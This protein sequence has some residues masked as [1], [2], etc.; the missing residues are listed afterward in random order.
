MGSFGRYDG[1]TETIDDYVNLH[2][3]PFA[4]VAIAQNESQH[5][6]T[7]AITTHWRWWL[8]D[9]SRW[10]FV[11]FMKRKFVHNNMNEV[12][13]IRHVQKP[14]AMCNVQK[15]AKT[16]LFSRYVAVWWHDPDKIMNNAKKRDAIARTRDTNVTLGV[17]V[18]YGSRKVLHMAF[19]KDLTKKP[20][21][22][23]TT[24]CTSLN[25]APCAN[26]YLP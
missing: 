24:F 19:W 1:I 20:G 26:I 11:P 21:A 2:S 6:N 12:L 10:F 8:F 4:R 13:E 7:H 3:D 16:P 14:C 25:P 22:G 15:C 17:I 23:L 5:H 18:E 9:Y